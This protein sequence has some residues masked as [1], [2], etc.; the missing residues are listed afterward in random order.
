MDHWHLVKSQ[1][2]FIKITFLYTIGLRK[3]IV[4]KYN[5]QDI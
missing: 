4:L 5:Y 1:T 2:L 3:G